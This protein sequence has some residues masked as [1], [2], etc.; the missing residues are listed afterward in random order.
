M[1][2]WFLGRYGMNLYRGCEHGCVY[3]D[4]RAERYYVTGDF[5]RDI[6]VKSNAVELFRAEIARRK[7]PG[8]VL[9]GGGV[10]DTY[11]PAEQR[12]RLARGIL[13]IVHDA[14]LPVHVL[15]KSCLVER[16]FDL[17]DAIANRAAVILSM[18]I[19]TLDETVRRRFEP[20]AA[21]IERRLTTLAR[22]KERG[23]GVGV[24]AMP[25]LPGISDQPDA[26]DQLVRR[27]ADVGADFVEGGALTL[28][29]GVQK[30]AF[31]E[32]VQSDYGS[33]VPG[34]RAAYRS[35]HASGSPAARYL[36]RVDDR[37]RRAR[38]TSGLAGRPPHSLFAGQMPEYSEVAV[39]LEHRGFE[40]GQASRGELAR[41]GW[42][43][44]NWARERL[45]RSGRRRGFTYRQVESEFRSLC[46]SGDLER[47]LAISSEAAREVVDVLARVRAARRPADSEAGT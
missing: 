28:R 26:I 1:D 24:M 39:L 18:S 21:P 42:A 36:A 4:G 19:Q 6:T 43:L 22:A 45:R 46:G 41:S 31:L 2:P 7:E 47:V 17:L 3:C 30:C 14:G 5:E 10:S 29:P 20:R 38:E 35:E 11:Q 32:V 44:Q 23:Y 8:F 13:Q 37:F 34:Y 9:L 15:T 27:A 40:R 12:Y 25:V 16:D 33:L